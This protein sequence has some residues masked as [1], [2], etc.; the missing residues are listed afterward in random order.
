MK[1]ASIA[2]RAFPECFGPEP[3]VGCD[4]DAWKIMC[5]DYLGICDTVE[6]RASGS[7]VGA[8]GPPGFVSLRIER[9][10]NGATSV[11][12]ARYDESD[13]ASEELCRRE[14]A[15]WLSETS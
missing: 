13:P 1:F 3:L 15:R 12:Y 8:E 2:R 5:T 14:V 7:S 6:T 4:D 11:K 10:K 9:V